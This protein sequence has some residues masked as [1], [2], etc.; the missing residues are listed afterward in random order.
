[1]V[2]LTANIHGLMLGEAA[3]KLSGAISAAGT[4][5]KGVRVVL[6]GELPA[7]QQTLSGLGTGLVLAVLVIF[8]S[9]GG[10]LSIPAARLIHC[11]DRLAAVPRTKSGK[12]HLSPHL[13]NKRLSSIASPRPIGKRALL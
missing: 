5:P 10:E 6:R 8:S 12:A 4:P 2:S 9:V 13:P 11:A 1:V 3:Q 7:L